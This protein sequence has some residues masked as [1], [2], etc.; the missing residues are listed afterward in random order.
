MGTKPLI[1]PNVQ[2][3]NILLG[4]LIYKKIE[5]SKDSDPRLKPFMGLVEVGE[6]DVYE[7]PG[8]AVGVTYRRFTLTAKGDKAARIV[9]PL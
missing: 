3:R 4:L 5:I 8:Q 9:A 2:R 6:L 7:T 1:R